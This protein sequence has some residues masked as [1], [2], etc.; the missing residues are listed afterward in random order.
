MKQYFYLHRSGD[1]TP[2]KKVNRV[3]TVFREEIFITKEICFFP[4]YYTAT[5]AKTG[6]AIGDKYKTIKECEKAVKAMI[7]K[8]G[9]KEFKKMI[10]SLTTTP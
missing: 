1:K 7:K 4:K 6:M 10:I 5:E 3:F 8:V 9:E 2:I